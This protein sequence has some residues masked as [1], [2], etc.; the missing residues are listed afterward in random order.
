[1]FASARAHTFEQLSTAID[2]AFARWDRSHLW[3][4]RFPGSTRI[5]IP[6]G[7]LDDVPGEVLDAGRTRLSRLK[8]GERFVY[9]FDFGDSWMHVCTVGDHH[10]DP[11]ESLG[12]VP[13]DPLPY[14]GWGD[15]PDQ[16]GRRWHEDDGESPLPPDPGTRDLPHL[17]PHWRPQE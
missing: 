13:A 5:E 7:W 8:P 10:I 2:V 1:M 4:F 6:Q 9:E 16:Y 3:A 17:L 15:I 14:F 12:I 11:L